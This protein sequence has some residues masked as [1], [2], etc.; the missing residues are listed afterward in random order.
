ML[1]SDGTGND[2]RV[3]WLYGVGPTPHKEE[4]VAF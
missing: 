4:V 2:V 3:L 1:E